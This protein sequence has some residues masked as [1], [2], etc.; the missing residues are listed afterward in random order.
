MHS[1][2]TSNTNHRGA[3]T[4]V[5]RV[6]TPHETHLDALRSAL[7]AAVFILFAAK[8]HAQLPDGPGKSETERICS[9]C[10]E[11]ERSISLHQD[12]DSWQATMNKMVGLGAKGTEK[13]F[14]AVVDYLAKN[15]AGEGIPKIDVN[16][17]E[18]ID[19]ESGL[20]LKRSEAAAIIQYRA[21]NGNFKS[22]DDLKKVPGID[23]AKIEAK[24]D[25]LVFK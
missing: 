3:D 24:K 23:P 9:Q 8:A 22:I 12:R 7:L 18:A 5:C 21:K 10:H 17:A 20:T 15:F 13:E 25:R 11:L 2:S 1:A 14:Q 6:V 4:R 16:Q 19:F